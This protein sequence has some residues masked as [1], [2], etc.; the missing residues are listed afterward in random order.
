MFCYSYVGCFAFYYIGDLNEPKLKLRAR[1]ALGHMPGLG[2]CQHA[3]QCSVC[4]AGST[5]CW[6]CILGT[7]SCLL[8]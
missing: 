4:H 6:L 5:D 3:Q 1:A 7:R 2:A 8:I